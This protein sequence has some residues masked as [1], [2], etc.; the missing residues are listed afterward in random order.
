[1]PQRPSLAPPALFLAGVVAL[2]VLVLPWV[3]FHE[4]V[5]WDVFNREAGI[6]AVGEP[7]IGP[8]LSPEEQVMMRTSIDNAKAA[9]SSG[10]RGYQQG[11]WVA[12]SLLSA[13]ALSFWLWARLR[14]GLAVRGEL[15]V[16]A[17]F[18]AAVPGA[19]RMLSDT[20]AAGTFESGGELVYTTTFA[21]WLAMIAGALI[22][23]AAVSCG[24]W[25]GRRHPAG[26]PAF[27]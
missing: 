7:V 12:L 14:S 18:A 9:A 21:P 22:A 1:M 11:W 23:A 27:P 26:D 3:R 25:A 20:N 10:L 19:M 2:I 6:S 8:D 5:F 24:A 16:V 17:G 13:S 4:D 15:F